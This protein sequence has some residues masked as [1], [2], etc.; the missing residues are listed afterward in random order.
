MPSGRV[1]I[2]SELLCMVFS[3]L[4]HGE[5]GSGDID[6]KD[7]FGGRWEKRQNK[8]LQWIKATTHVCHHWQE[9]ALRCSSLWNHRHLLH[10]FWARG[11]LERS[12]NTP[13]VIQ[14]HNN[15]LRTQ[16]VLDASIV[17]STFN[18]TLRPQPSTQS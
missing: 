17:S 3:F 12:S 1:I 9:V 14:F 13:L 4:A 8:S 10:S 5:D 6:E 16:N 15:F 18:S 11:T 2:P 7:D